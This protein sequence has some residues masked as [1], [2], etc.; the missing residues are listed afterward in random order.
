MKPEIKKKWIKALLSGKYKQTKGRL[1]SS[2]GGYCCLGVLCDLHR[3]EVKG[4]WKGG[5]Y[6]DVG[7]ILPYDVQ[8][9]AGIEDP[10]GTFGDG[11]DDFLTK[12]NDDG[13]RFSTIAKIIDK[14]F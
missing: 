4:E 7:D 2:R 14:Y 8:K 12:L 1:K 9:W 6:L 11:T 13:K 10:Y 3:K 5:Q